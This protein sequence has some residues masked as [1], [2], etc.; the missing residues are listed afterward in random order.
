MTNLE[1]KPKGLKEFWSAE[2]MPSVWEQPD[3]GPSD[4]TSDKGEP[5]KGYPHHSSTAVAVAPIAPEGSLW[6]I[7]F[8]SV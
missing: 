1:S 8:G 4:W 5:G 7:R 3:Q 2:D 6:S